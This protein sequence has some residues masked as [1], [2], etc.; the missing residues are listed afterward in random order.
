M[1]LRR[2]G[3]VVPLPDAYSRVTN[4]ERF[5]PLLEHA[6][7]VCARL[8]ATY[9][10]TAT[11]AFALLPHLIWQ[12]EHERPPV[13]LTPATPTAATLRFAFTTF[14][15]VIVRYGRWHAAPFPSCGCDACGATA[16]GE[17]ERLDALVDGVV[18][19]RLTE[20]LRV[21][22]LGRARLSY[23]FGGEE[24]APGLRQEGWASVT[25]AV[26]RSLGRVGPR[27]IEWAPWARRQK[28]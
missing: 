26:A 12:V 28:P 13:T 23:R 1:H 7:A 25:R 3:P 22:L 20:E 8:H 4:P 19:G 16:E 10:V 17:I 15:S 27:R 6:G 18:G 14:P 5:L 21:P 11:E 9:D 24:G 2:R